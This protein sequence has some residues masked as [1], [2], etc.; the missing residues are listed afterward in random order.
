MKDLIVVG[1]LVVSFAL[2]VTAHVAITYG[3]AFRPPRWRALAALFVA[4][5]APYWA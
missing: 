1:T 4:P 5:L 2:F 3:L